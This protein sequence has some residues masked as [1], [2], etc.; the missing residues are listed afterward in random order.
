MW[1]RLYE[2]AYPQPLILGDRQLIN[3]QRFGLYRQNIH[4]HLQINNLQKDDE[5][6]YL[7]KSGNAIQLSYHLIIHS[8]KFR[9]SQKKKPQILDFNNIFLA[10]TCIDIIPNNIY[11]TLDQ[12][13]RLVCRIRSMK[14]FDQTNLYAKWT[15]ND[16]LLNN[17]TQ[18]NSNYSSINGILYETLFIKHASFADMGIYKCQYG[19]KLTATSKVI[20]NQSKLWFF[21]FFFKVER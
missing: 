16:N 1:F 2:D 4:R 7:C 11:V 9:L 18:Y 13:I 20:V 6:Y 19:S 10:N 17:F 8:M 15:R 5:G 14:N 21:V 3:D 12:P